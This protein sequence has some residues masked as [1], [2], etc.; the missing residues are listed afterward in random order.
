VAF[1]RQKQFLVNSNPSSIASSSSPLPARH[2]PPMHALSLSV[3]SLAQLLLQH[4]QALNQGT[5]RSVGLN[6]A[7][8]GRFPKHFAHAI[9]SLYISNNC[10]TNLNGLDQ[11]ENLEIFSATNNLI[12]SI[13]DLNSLSQ[14]KHLKKV[15]LHGNPVAGLPF[16]REYILNSC[17]NLE[18]IDGQK[19]SYLDRTEAV[20]VYK[21][22]LHCIRQFD[23]LWHEILLVYILVLM[24]CIKC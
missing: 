12:Q 21:R 10:L 19:I 15:S 23:I 8:I 2:A 9:H 13:E 16:Y 17:P 20:M 22:V 5:L 14:L 3:H 24:D 1:H 6:V 4:P 7:V 11:F 18:S